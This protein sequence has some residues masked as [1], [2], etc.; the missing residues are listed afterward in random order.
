MFWLWSDP[1]ILV[2]ISFLMELMI[3]ARS[4]WACASSNSQTTSSAFTSAYTNGVL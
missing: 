2:L 1:T 4:S 3:W